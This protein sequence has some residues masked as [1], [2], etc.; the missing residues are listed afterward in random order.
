VARTV[1]FIGFG[2]ENSIQNQLRG[3]AQE[4]K[5][6]GGPHFVLVNAEEADKVRETLEGT[7][8]QVVPVA[9][10]EALPGLLEEL[11]SCVGSVAAPLR[12]V[13]DP[14]RYFEWIER[15]CG[16]IEL[17]ALK[18]SSGR[19][20]RYPISDL[21]I[22]PQARGSEQ[23]GPLGGA[24]AGLQSCV[25]EGDAGSGKST[26]LKKLA[27]DYCQSK[28]RFPILI[29][30]AELDLFLHRCPVAQNGAPATATDGRWLVYFLS[31]REWGLAESFFTDHLGR[32]ETTVL[33]DGLD[34]AA[35]GPRRMRM[36]R[37]VENA[38]LLYP[39]CQ[40]VVTTRP[41]AYEGM[42]VIGGFKRVAIT[43][44]DAEQIDGF[45][46]MWSLLLHEGKE[47]AA[48]EH[49]TGL[50]RALDRTDIRRLAR[51]PL[52]LTALAVV[53]WNDKVLP[54][55]RAA[56]YESIL[57]WMAEARLDRPERLP[58]DKCLGLMGTLA[59]KMQSYAGGHR[60]SLGRGD[61]ANLLATEF[62]GVA[63]ASRFLLAE[64][65]DSGIITSNGNELRFRHRTF[66]EYLAAWR[67]S[68]MTDDELWKGAAPYLYA[69]EWR[70]VMLLLAGSLCEA[71][72]HGRLSLFLGK[73]LQTPE[74]LPDQ[75]RCVAL[76]AAMM[77]DLRAA[78]YEMPEA[79]AVR[80]EALKKEVQAIF[81]VEGANGIPVRVRAAAAEALGVEG[82][83]RLYLPADERY[84]VRLEGGQ[85]WMGAQNKDRMEHNFDEQADDD[86][87]VRETRIEAFRLGRYPVTVHEFERFLAACP[88]REAPADWDQ[89]LLTPTRPVV[90]VAWEQ[91]QAYCESVGGRLPR[92][93]EWE[94][95]ARGREG[96]TYPW[97]AETP[98][99]WRANFES[100]AGAPTPIGM[101]PTGDTPDGISDMAGNIWE[102]TGGGNSKERK[103]V[104]VRGGGYWG[105]RSS[106]RGTF[107]S[108]DLPGGIND[109][110]G[111]R[112]LRE[113]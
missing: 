12:V 92:E 21:Y 16:W 72:G 73:V 17:K 8:V 95:A 82:H 86:D 19:A 99:A 85:F 37:I 89:Q 46:W 31:K 20:G 96:R 42:A 41:S 15:E 14:T 87:T 61:A 38:R 88:G 57:T 109:D 28:V 27:W 9:G 2:L 108:Y 63:A 22:E 100:D 3:V 51:N 104:R 68:G 11:I 101:F 90:F 97:G 56:L 77:N 80:Y 69:R 64:E 34:E 70:E 75:A 18:I 79:E 110:I 54:E 84:W 66:Q 35:D 5:W 43:D 78:E 71:K 30:V 13:H 55:Q 40:V 45:I 23:V 83:P 81:T 76:V 39:N 10:F 67:L 58:P 6:A 53:H 29:R 60:V 7:R 112:C 107:R 106:L 1:L 105:G 59:L 36:A 52:M 4:F 102:W 26:F 98:D 65:I 48:K 50:R 91:A 32:P 24:V 25:V 103:D 93:E 94:Y 44:L 113:G 33:L 49:Q 47:E 74:S 62:G 111:F